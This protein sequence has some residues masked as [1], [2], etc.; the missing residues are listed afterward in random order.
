ML[1]LAEKSSIVEVLATQVLHY[2]MPQIIEICRNSDNSILHLAVKASL[3]GL[4]IFEN[5]CA[6]QI[7]ARRQKACS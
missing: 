1:Q 7:C 5:S 3:V 6:S 4:H 2:L